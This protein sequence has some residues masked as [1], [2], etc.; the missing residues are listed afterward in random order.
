MRLVLA[1]ARDLEVAKQA[2]G[3]DTYGKTDNP[4]LALMN[5]EDHILIEGTPDELRTLVEQLASLYQPRTWVVHAVWGL[6]EHSVEVY[7]TE[8]AAMDGFR[9]LV[10]YIEKEHDVELEVDGDF[11]TDWDDWEV[12]IL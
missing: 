11:A 2:R 4:A 10:A 12:R 1:E 8:A 9:E 6:A 5:D 3:R 7:Y